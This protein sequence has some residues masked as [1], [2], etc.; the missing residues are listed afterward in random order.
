MLFC[1]HEKQNECQMTEAKDKS[2]N[3]MRDIK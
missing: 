1:I 2:Y 3:K